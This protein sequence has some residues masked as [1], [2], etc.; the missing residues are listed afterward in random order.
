MAATKK[1]SSILKRRQKLLSKRN[2]Q[3]PK[4]GGL[5]LERI[6][7]YKITTAAI[8]I[9]N[10]FEL[11]Q[12]KQETSN[13]GLRLIRLGKY[14]DAIEIYEQLAKECPEAPQIL[15]NL[16]KAYASA[17][18]NKKADR[19]ALENYKNAPDYLFAKVAYAG[20][21]AG[22]KKSKLIPKV[23]NNCFSLKALYPDRDVFHETEV[24]AF[25]NIMCLY[26][27]YEE[28][29]K[30]ALAHFRLLLRLES[31]RGAADLLR[32]ALTILQ[33]QQET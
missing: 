33:I 14:S 31:G 3:S 29:Y 25:S 23:F 7:N 17:G 9:P 13:E 18:L 11:P 26:F 12:D 24:V 16:A 15:N 28:N 22:K 8:K 21:L 27:I 32:P 10:L 30:R 5:S 2:G 19:I 4:V 6:L 1:Q 20:L